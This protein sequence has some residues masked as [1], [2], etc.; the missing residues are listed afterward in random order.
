[1]HTER[2]TT[3]GQRGNEMEHRERV[4]SES[5]NEF[6]AVVSVNTDES[7]QRTASCRRLYSTQTAYESVTIRLKGSKPKHVKYRDRHGS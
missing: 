7:H 5:E 2:V 4:Q 3:E 6:T 1:M